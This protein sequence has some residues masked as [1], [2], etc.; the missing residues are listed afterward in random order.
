M[1]ALLIAGT[2]LAGV[3]VSRV[4]S[5]WPPVRHTGDLG[6]AVLFVSDPATV[7]GAPDRPVLACASRDIIVL[8]NPCDRLRFEGE[9]FAR[10]A[11]HEMAHINGWSGNHPRTTQDP[12]RQPQ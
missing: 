1:K 3:T 4:D 9:E 2:L 11:C 12:P 8:P 5:G 6:V 7:C 10:L